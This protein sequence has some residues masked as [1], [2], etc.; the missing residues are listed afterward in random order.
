VK[1]FAIRLEES[2][3]R[4]RIEFEGELDVA[5]TASAEEELRRV[6]RRGA[7]L[8]VL[9]LRRLTFMDSTGL[10]LLVSADARARGGDYRL[11]IIRGPDAVHRVLELTGLDLRLNVIDDPDQA[12]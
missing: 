8:I 7:R 9:D 6:E 3:G 12:A 5:T 1:R 4:V 10:R 11:A 2:E